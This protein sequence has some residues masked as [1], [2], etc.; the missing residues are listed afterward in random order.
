MVTEADLMAAVS[1]AQDMLYA[2]R[3]MEALEL[4][5]KLLIILEVDNKGTVDLIN[6]WSVGGRTRHVDTRQLFL[7]GMKDQGVLQVKWVKGEENEVDMF[8]KNLLG[9]LFENIVW[10]LMA[11]RKR[12]RR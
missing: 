10:C 11:I 6:S 8:T 7:S 5:V 4:K 9:P 12:V 1:C 3:I 2:N